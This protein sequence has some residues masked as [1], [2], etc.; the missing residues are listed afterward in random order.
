MR[1]NLVKAAFWLVLAGGLCAVLLRGP[2]LAQKPMPKDV[3]S[4]E[5][6]FDSAGVALAGTLLLPKTEAGKRL[7]AVLLLSSYGQTTRDGF[8]FDTVEQPVYRELADHLARQGFGVLRYD[9]RCT[10]A[11]GCKPKW[12]FD[13]LVDDAREAMAFLR[14]RPE[15]D[16]A[17]LFVFGHGEG[18]FV[19][20]VLGTS[21]EKL[22][23][24]IL[25]ASPGR[26]WNKLLRDQFQ[27]QMREA[28]KPEPEISAFI[29]KFDGIARTIGS[30]NHEDMSKGLDPQQPQ[31]AVVINLINRPEFV[32]PLFIN[33]PLQVANSVKAPVL[34]LQG[35]KDIV[36]SVK[37]AKF[38]NEALLRSNHS[39]TT[40][41]VF[42]DVDH[43][44]KTNKGP[45]SHAVSR[46]A[47]RPLD[48]GL[49]AALVEWLQKRVS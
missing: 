35:G 29:A 17:K 11:S 43:L 4:E 37:D 15:V 10:G 39:D 49:L 25:A 8:K 28:G 26:T 45:A 12:T 2:A 19:G 16:P 41:Q 23:G 14:K 22:A 38:L 21:D 6:K 34:I 31:A 7:P 33:D 24:V 18:G 48:T 30:A 44:L 40:L 5:V 42:P 3:R 47:S 20:S 27:Q 9:K 36:V 1:N 46:D 13:D 32:I